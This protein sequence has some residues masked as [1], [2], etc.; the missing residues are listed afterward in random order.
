MIAPRRAGRLP[1]PSGNGA[2]IAGA[3]SLVAAALLV[4]AGWAAAGIAGLSPQGNPI[5][6]AVGLATGTS[7]WSAAATVVLVVIIVAVAVLAALVVRAVMGRRSGAG[8]LDNLAKSM[9]LPSDVRPLSMETLAEDA[10]RLGVAPECGPGV[11]IG[12]AVN[13][14]TAL[15]TSWE[16]TQLWVMGPRA[17][18]TSCLCIP[19]VLA[20]GGPVV[21]TSNKRDL[22]DAT[23]GPRSQ[24]GLVRVHDPQG[25]AGQEATWWWSPLSYITDSP[26]ADEITSLFAAATRDATAKTDAYFDTAAQTLVSALLL[27]AAK[28]GKT[29]LDVH[30]WVRRPDETEPE[31]LLI[32][33]GER[34]AAIDV[35]SARMKTPKQ[36]DGIYGSAEN[37]LSWLRNP[38]LEPWITPGEGRPEFDAEEFVRSKDTLY[39]LSKEGPGSARALTASLTVAVTRAAERYGISQGGRLARPLLCV[40]DEAANICR[41]P[42][43]PDLYSHYGSRGI[44]LTTYL[45][46]WSQ[47][48]RVWGK[49]GMTQM[50]D[51]ANVRGIGPGIAD[52]QFAGTISKLVGPHDV[53]TRS[54]SNSMRSGHSVN[55]QLRREQIL[56][57]ADVSALPQGRAVVLP[58]GSPS[59]MLATQHWSTLEI[60]DLITASI[61]HY[62]R[63]GAA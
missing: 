58:S 14:G 22:L 3:G 13:G 37:L 41:W 53:R 16:W 61:E 29:L 24:R 42:Q 46:S 4:V 57:V 15:G 6:W 44:V 36:R 43:L 5:G 51:A 49:E 55:H 28:G 32:D 20:T 2:L 52:D 10:R 59:I 25:L 47:G 27:A 35:E 1:E 39:L 48:V 11:P 21:A 8:R 23:R 30:E 56:E 26:R 40:L 38:A 19:Q 34:S 54:A 17:G 9:S 18:K 62:S 12:K 33:A 50:W 63:E 31:D 45:Q 7:R 60:A